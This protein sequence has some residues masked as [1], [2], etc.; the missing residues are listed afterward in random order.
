MGEK[1]CGGQISYIAQPTE[2]GVVQ[3]LAVAKARELKILSAEKSEGKKHVRNV[4]PH[5]EEACETLLT[6]VILEMK[7]EIAAE[8]GGI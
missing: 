4:Y 1:V 6:K 8:K 2:Q 7:A 3:A 5:S